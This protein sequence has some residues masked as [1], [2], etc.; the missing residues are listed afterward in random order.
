MS[1]NP[2]A[3]RPRF[4]SRRDLLFQSGQG[5]GGL[6][7]A[8]LLHQDGLLGATGCENPA[9]VQ[10]PYA[11]KAP[12]FKPRA[13]NVISLF[14][15]GGVSHLDTFDPKPALDK[16]H[17]QPL[18][19]EKDVQ[20]Q[21][22]YPGP[23]MR[24]PYKFKR[25]GNAGIEVSELF[26]HMGSMVDD[27]ALIR[28]AVGRSNDHSIS[29]FEWNT[30]A[31]IPGFPAYGAWVAYGLGTENQNLPAFV[32][33]HDRKGGPYNGPN[34]WGAGFLPAGYQGTVFRS[35]GDPIL[36]LRPPSA[37]VTPEQQR[38]RL[39]HLAR[40]NHQH[41]ERFPGASELTAR[42][43]SYELAYRMQSC[44]PEAVDLS[45]ESEETKRLYGMDV[46]ESEPFGRQCLLSRRLVE[47]G[48][49]FI[50]LWSGAYVNDTVDTWDA[51]NSVVDNHG[52]HAPEVDK[53]I[54]GL[55]A[56]LKRRGLLDETL[57]IFHTEFG[58]MPISQRGVGRD[59]NP[60]AFSFWMSGA[61][62]PGGQVIGE[63]DEFGYKVARQP[64]T[65][66]DFHATVLHLLGI[67]HKRLTYFFNGRHMRLTD[68]HGE[69]I[70]QIAGA[71]PATSG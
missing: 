51:H 53:P 42:I 12:H 15:C 26:P 59:H 36:D 69:L 31:L 64:V 30:G 25:Y 71:N 20:V 60:N 38:S 63:S 19:N 29:H 37:Y 48:V 3:E 34:N 27:L 32:V 43:N 4:M 45:Q 7:L 14:M 16:Y 65:V 50:Q 8:Y 18:P 23:I 33:I 22:G 6:A 9:G 21:Q 47:R 40:L 5:I 52:M 58:R 49:R 2:H 66:F 61:G 1:S 68:V 62:I 10:S 57:V 54:T 24:S 11:P 44:A 28:S 17:G 35:T 55:I 56:D 41:E 13:K 46:P 39:D 67:D 70:P